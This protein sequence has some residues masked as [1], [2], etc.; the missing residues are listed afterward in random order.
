ME[1]RVRV[2]LDFRMAMGQWDIAE[3]CITTSITKKAYEEI[4]QE[5]KYNCWTTAMDCEAG[6]QVTAMLKALVKLQGYKRLES[7]N[8]T[9]ESAEV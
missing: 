5:L 1:E 2:C 7:W 4:T 8:I 3:N 6:Q 9:L